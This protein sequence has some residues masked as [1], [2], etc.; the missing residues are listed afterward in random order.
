MLLRLIIGLVKGLVLGGLAGFGL[1]AA[2]FVAPSALVAYPAAIVLGLLIACLAGKP[3]WAKG[4]RIEVGMK[5]VVAA[6]FA[7]LLLFL[8][9][10]FVTMGLPIDPSV[11]GLETTTAALGTFAVTSYAMVAAVLAGF[12][13]A[14]ND[15]GEEE[16]GDAKQAKAAATGKR[17]AASASDDAEALAD[18]EQADDAARRK[19]RK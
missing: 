11:I 12:F 3:I 18:F 19:L 4:A 8:A 17:I 16:K 10:R 1:A 6:I 15:P 14:D 13:D 5:A 7:P 9:R 2:G